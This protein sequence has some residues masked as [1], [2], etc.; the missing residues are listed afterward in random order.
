MYVSTNPINRIIVT[1]RLIIMHFNG[2]LQ[3]DTFFCERLFK[4][5]A[6]SFW[7]AR[8][9]SGCA[10]KPTRQ[11]CPATDFEHT[12]RI[13]Y[14]SAS[15]VYIPSVSVLMGPLNY[16]VYDYAHAASQARKHDVRCISEC[17]FRRAPRLNITMCREQRSINVCAARSPYAMG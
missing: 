10:Q 5:R 15:L 17:A 7:I 8:T 1:K 3:I 14:I 11:I 12:Q 16:S 2:R 6:L 13:A 4:R 9:F